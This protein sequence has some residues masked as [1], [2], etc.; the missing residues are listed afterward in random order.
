MSRPIIDHRGRELAELSIGV[1][2]G[3]RAL[4]QTDDPVVIY[5]SSGTG[6][7]E[8]SLVNCLSP[9]D[10][11][12]VCENG[13]FAREWGR[14][15]ERL[16]FVVQKLEGDWR[17]GP[18]PESIER[19]LREDRKQQIKAV[20]VVHNETSTG[21]TSRVHEI[22]RALNGSGHPAL[23]L[24]DT[25]SSLGSI[26]Y[27]HDEWEVDVTVSASQKGLML[28]PGLGLNIVSQKARRAAAQA[29]SPKGY[30]DWSRFLETGTTGAFPFTP[31]TTL[32][33]GLEE[34]LTMLQE[35][36][37][38]YANP[39]VML[40]GRIHGSVR[41][42]GLVGRVGAAGSK[43]RGVGEFLVSVVSA[44]ARD[45]ACGCCSDRRIRVGHARVDCG[46]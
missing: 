29:G 46:C 2:E 6:A 21:V 9:G 24:V 30:W 7:W 17:Y 42:V 10:A 19:V 36:G 44:R 28:P 31:A 25:I 20:L 40:L 11:V 14:L 35:E 3:L 26:D 22:R 12:L 27:K 5:A 38:G 39:S 1:H 23:L 18:N 4:L 15:A 33:F 45:A 34:A 16:G 43:R 41:R 8:A 32:L 13:H 37:V